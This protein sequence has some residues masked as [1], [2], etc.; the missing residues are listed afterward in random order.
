VRGRRLDSGPVV[1]FRVDDDDLLAV[2][3][4]DRLL[5]YATYGDRGRA[6]N[7]SR[8]F[9]S[10][11]DESTRSMHDLRPAAAGER[12][13]MEEGDFRL[14]L[15]ASSLGGLRIPRLRPWTPSERAPATW[16]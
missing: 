6:V 16:A 8:G 7:L 11:W 14:G 3:F 9:N 10:V 15:S 4:T 13:P 1:T 12:P 5:E 2:D